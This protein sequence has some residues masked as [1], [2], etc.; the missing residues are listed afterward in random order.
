MFVNLAL[1]WN[2]HAWPWLKRNWQWILLPVGLLMLYARLRAKPQVV[3]SEVAGAAATQLDATSKYV[4]RVDEA[5]E[6]RD[7]QR[8]QLEQEHAEDVTQF[9]EDAAEEVPRLQADPKQANDFLKNVGRKMRD[10]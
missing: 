7:T 8:K 3:P 10:S 6:A 1:W 9:V 5:V 2:L 4:Q